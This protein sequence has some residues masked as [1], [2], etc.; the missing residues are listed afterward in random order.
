MRLALA[1]ALACAW[2]PAVA[3]AQAT[4]VPTDRVV[5]GVSIRVSA[6]TTSQ[7][8]GL[9]QPG[10]TADFIGEVPKWYRIDHP[11]LGAG[12][13]SKSW[14]RLVPDPANA[15]TDTFDV[16]V[17]DVATGLAILVRGQ[18]FTLVY[19][20]GS[21]DDLSGDRF[22][23]FM[24]V[25]APG[26]TTI[27]HVVISHA[28]R[29]HISMLPDLLD[30]VQVSHIWDSGVIYASCTYQ[31]LLEAIAIEGAQYHTMQSPGQRTVAFA[32]EC[33]ATGSQ[34]TMTFAARLNTVAVQLGNNASMTFLHLNGTQ[35]GDLNDNSLVVMLE[36]G[37]TRILLPGDVGGGARGAPS[38]PPD[39]GSVERVLIDCCVDELSADILVLGHHGSMTS[40]R[41][42]FLDAVEARDYIVSSG[43]KLYGSVT[44]PDSAVVNFVAARPNARVWRTDADDDAC[45][46]NP[47]KIGNDNDNKAGGCSNIRIH[48]DGNSGNY[49]ITIM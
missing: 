33:S 4:V 31:E 26:T 13:V 8:I 38:E 12:F 34:V 45:L 20:A 36:L 44:L 48:I 25:V 28:H 32:R 35:G 17:V 18:D 46:T 43:P 21:N 39:V 3:A 11:S 19:D 9:L 14:T 23:A 29:D 10:D 2:V 40:S 42:E 7:K 47:D 37:G 24:D 16:Y 49:E 30:S 6:T 22:G 41:D 27:D 15:S 5:N 1:G